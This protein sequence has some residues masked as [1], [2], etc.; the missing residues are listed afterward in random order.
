[1]GKNRRIGVVS[2]ALGLLL[3]NV[4]LFCLEQ[5]KT[6]TFWVTAGFVWAAFLFSLVLSMAVWK[7]A[8]NPEEQFLHIPTLVI[9]TGYMIV[10]I[11]ISIVFALGSR[12]IS[13]NVTLCVN[14][15][16]LIAAWLVTFASF[17][18]NDHIRNIRE[19]QK[20]HHIK[21]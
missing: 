5:G 6:P 7:R 13:C 9:L 21:L 18:G 16:L 2:W 8:K 11:P 12:L 3:V 4:L 1:M 10:Q 19:R 14:A 20:N 15:V 17:T